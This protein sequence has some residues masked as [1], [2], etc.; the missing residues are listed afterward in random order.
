MIIPVSKPGG[1]RG[2]CQSFHLRDHTHH[3][4]KPR[5]R[6]VSVRIPVGREEISLIKSLLSISRLKCKMADFVIDHLAI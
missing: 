6:E 2:Y 5:A 3:Y 1:L 4:V